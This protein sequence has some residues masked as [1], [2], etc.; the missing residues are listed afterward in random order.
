MA[1]PDL[2]I[3]DGLPE[4]VLLVD[5]EKRAREP[6]DQRWRAAFENSAIGIIM[7]D[8]KGRYFA[9][10]SAFLNMLGYTES[11]LYQLTFLDVTHEDDRKANQE[12]VV[13][14]VEGKR[15][16]FEIEKRYRRKDG[17]LVW[18]RTNVARVP[19][20]P[21]WFGIVEDISQ[22]KR[23]E[24]EL[25]LQIEVV[26][27]NERSLR[28]LTETIP[29]MLWSADADGGIDYCNR[30]VLDYTGLST[31]QVRGAGWMNAVYQDDL[32]KMTR[33]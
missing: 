20:E 8:F 28:E 29:Q 2:S 26:R 17:T 15:Q 18:V 25:R 3:M 27:A 31:E 11:E 32:E 4:P 1:R 19:G 14:L 10:N 21:F 7:A 16:H 12:L 24:E 13:E 22:R 30:R 33:A 6:N 9:A 23:V 5:P